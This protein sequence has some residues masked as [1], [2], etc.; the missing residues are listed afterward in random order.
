[1][2]RARRGEATKMRWSRRRQRGT[3]PKRLAAQA[4][5]QATVPLP[6]LLQQRCT[7]LLSAA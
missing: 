2:G 4:M 5:A 3:R 1:M 7:L 6:E